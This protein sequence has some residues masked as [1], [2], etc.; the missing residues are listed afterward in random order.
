MTLFPRCDTCGHRIWPWQRMGW[1][2]RQMNTVNWHGKCGQ[3]DW[4]R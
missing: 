3:P 2:V 4:S 1:I